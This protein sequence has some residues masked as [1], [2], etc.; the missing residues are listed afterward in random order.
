M[1]FIFWTSGRAYVTNGFC[2]RAHSFEELLLF[3]VRGKIRGFCW[4]CCEPSRILA[5]SFPCLPEV[6]FQLDWLILLQMCVYLGKL[7]KPLDKRIF[8]MILFDTLACRISR[9]TGCYCHI[10][11]T[12]SQ[13]QISGSNF[14]ICPKSFCMSSFLKLSEYTVCGFKQSVRRF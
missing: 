9:G 8:L 13:K 10:W 3:W 12:V 2:C 5:V 7:W 14:N 6:Y 1:W 11:L 4:A